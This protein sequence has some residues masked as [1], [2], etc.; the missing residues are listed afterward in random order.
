MPVD[1][2]KVNDLAFDFHDGVIKEC[3]LNGQDFVTKDLMLE[4]HGLPNLGVLVQLQSAERPAFWLR[5]EEVRMF[6]FHHDREVSPAQ[7]EDLEDQMHRI[8]FLNCVVEA[9]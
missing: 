3:W 6:T 2:N 1:W 9:R 8:E 4:Y 7:I 5:F